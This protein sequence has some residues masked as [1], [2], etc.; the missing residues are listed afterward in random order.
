MSVFKRLGTS[1]VFGA[2]VLLLLCPT[3]YATTDITWYRVGGETALDTMELIVA[4]DGVTG[5]S[6]KNPVDTVVVT[7][8]SG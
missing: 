4:K 5:F 6:V 7:T 1:A 8:V 2:L 3:A